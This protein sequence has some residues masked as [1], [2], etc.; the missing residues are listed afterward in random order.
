ME[1]FEIDSILIV[2]HSEEIVVVIVRI[3]KHTWIVSLFANFRYWSIIF[4]KIMPEKSLLHG[5]LEY[6]KVW[7]YLLE[8]Q[9]KCSLIH[10]LLQENGNSIH[11]THALSGNNRKYLCGIV[12]LI[13]LYVFFSTTFCH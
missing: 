2:G 12:E 8:S 11:I 9:L 4:F 3:N 10:I 7:Q 5:H 1:H 13:P 6:V